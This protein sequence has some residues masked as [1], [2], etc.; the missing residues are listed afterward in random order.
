MEM[1]FP[2]HEGPKDHEDLITD[3]VDA[4]E[5]IMDVVHAEDIVNQVFLGD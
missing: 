4:E 2:K 1:G 3:F 5:A